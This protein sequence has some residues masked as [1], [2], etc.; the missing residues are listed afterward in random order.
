M[1]YLRF[2]FA[3]RPLTVLIPHKDTL[4]SHKTPRE[5]GGRQNWVPGP[6]GRRFRPKSGDLAGV[7][8]RERRGSSWGA[9]RGSIWVL[10]WGRGCAGEGVQWRR[11]VPAAVPP[12][13]ARSRTGQT[14]RQLGK[15]AH[16]LGS[17]FGGGPMTGKGA[18]RSSTRPCR[19]RRAERLGTGR[20][21]PAHTR[22]SASPFIGG[23][24]LWWDVPARQGQ[25]WPREAA[26]PSGSAV[27]REWRRGTGQVPTR[28]AL[29]RGASGRATS[30]G[31]EPREGARGGAGR[32][33]GAYG[34]SDR[35]DVAFR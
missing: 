31:C 25:H 15:L 8:G 4:G 17:R 33:Y 24:P 3:T 26:C 27:R 5:E 12:A 29:V 32:P 1:Y 13:P 19:G 7:P 22:W 2:T 20:E 35:R 18:G 11:P 9:H 28:G 34:A 23:R 14:N 21:W 6:W 16:G 30:G 10:G